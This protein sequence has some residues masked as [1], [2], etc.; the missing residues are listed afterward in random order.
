MLE[1]VQVGGKVSVSVDCGGSTVEGE[2]EREMP[3]CLSGQ[4]WLQ[5]VGEEQ[6]QVDRFW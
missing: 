2:R 4:A 3:A 5:G 6:C 1:A